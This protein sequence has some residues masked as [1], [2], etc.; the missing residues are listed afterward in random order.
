MTE[1]TD[2]DPAEIRSLYVE[3]LARAAYLDWCRYR[4]EE[5]TWE[6]DCTGETREHYLCHADMLADALAEAGLL[7]AGIEERDQVLAPLSS[8]R[9]YRTKKT[10]YV[11]PWREVS[12]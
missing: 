10:R 4:A 6:D 8:N 2:K 3:T 5:S 9:V 12:D 7:P 11:G 1:P